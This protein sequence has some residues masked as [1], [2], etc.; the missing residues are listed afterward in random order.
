MILIVPNISTTFKYSSAVLLTSHPTITL[1][2]SLKHFQ[3]PFLIPTPLGKSITK[4]E[5][6]L[7]K[8]SSW[9]SSLIASKRK[10][11]NPFPTSAQT[12]SSL[13]I[14]L[15]CMSC[16]WPRLLYAQKKVQTSDSNTLECALN[17]FQFICGM[18]LQE[19]ILDDNTLNKKSWANSL[20]E[21]TY[22]VWVTWKHP[23]FLVANL[24]KYVSS[25]EGQQIFTQ[26]TKYF[27]HSV[28]D[29]I[30]PE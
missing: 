23:T 6:I 14:F 12:V 16:C 1:E 5:K 26:M 19:I 25:V 3:I 7:T 13:G 24:Q 15:R 20:L 10:T 30:M 11:N 18:S 27:F 21:K 28:I 17:G 4:Q 9:A 22:H 8:N 29:A 2:S